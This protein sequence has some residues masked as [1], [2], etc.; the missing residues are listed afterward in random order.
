[1][2]ENIRGQFEK[3]IAL[4]EGERSRSE[5]LAGRLAASESAA[6]AYK[7]QIKDLT[8]QIDNLKLSS[9]FNPGG[10]SAESRETLDRIIAEIDRCIK[11]LEK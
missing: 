3:L 8:R 6:Q 5:D 9:A 4:Y 1:M 7:E 11:L 10:P 2:L